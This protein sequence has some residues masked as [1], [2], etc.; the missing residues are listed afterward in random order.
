[1]SEN[2]KVDIIP[3]KDHQQ[4][5]EIVSKHLLTQNQRSTG[6]L[7]NSPFEGCAYRGRNGLKCAVGCLIPDELYNPNIEDITIDG[8]LEN[9]DNTN[10]KELFYAVEYRFLTELQT[11]HDRVDPNKWECSLRKLVTQQG[12]YYGITLPEF[13]KEEE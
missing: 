8:L 6:A 10:L 1:M 4:I 11:I 12:E 7:R 13:L 2:K 9:D 5:F 3:Y